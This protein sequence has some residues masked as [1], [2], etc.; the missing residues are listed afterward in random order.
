MEI[1]LAS[2]IDSVTRRVADKTSELYPAE[3]QGS[4]PDAAAQGDHTP[5]ARIDPQADQSIERRSS[6]GELNSTAVRNHRTIRATTVG[7][8]IA[9]PAP[10]I[11]SPTRIVE[12]EPV[13]LSELSERIPPRTAPTAELFST[14]DEPVPLAAAKAPV[15]DTDPPARK[16][17]EPAETL[18]ASIL[19]VVSK[20]TQPPAVSSLVKLSG[21]LLAIW[22]LPPLVET[23]SVPGL[24][25][26]PTLLS[27]LSS[28]TELPLLVMTRFR[29]AEKFESLLDCTKVRVT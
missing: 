6:A 18:L 12:P 29:P 7:V 3:G 5:I 28:R 8:V 24:A 15:R 9:T 13:M 25:T 1:R 26:V 14:I 10:P 23:S 27:R 21:E 19:P 4:T 16:L 22:K 11:M 17:T 20:T 2:V